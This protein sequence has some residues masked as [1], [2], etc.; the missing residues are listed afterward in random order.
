MR[1][2]CIKH[3]HPTVAAVLDRIEIDDC[4]AAAFKHLSGVN[5]RS[6]QYPNPFTDISILAEFTQIEELYLN[7][8]QVSDLSPISQFHN[9]QKLHAEHCAVE[10]ISPLSN[11]SNWKI[12][13]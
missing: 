10:N 6:F 11:L 8:S 4:N 13:C 5:R 12:Y 3:Q 9:L 7:D 2:K 1:W